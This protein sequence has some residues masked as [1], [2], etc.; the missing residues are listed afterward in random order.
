MKSQRGISALSLM[1]TIVIIIMVAGY[2]LL[3]SRDT[4][5]EGNVATVYSEMQE[6]IEAAKG[7][8]LD[9]D[10]LEENLSV[11]ELESITEMNPRVGNKLREGKKYYYFA[12]ADE[13]FSDVMKDSLNE[14][15]GLRSVSGSYIV[16]INDLGKVEVYLVDGININGK[17]CY[18]YEEIYA[19]YTEVNQK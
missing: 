16:A 2:S 13:D 3:F 8:S 17:F 9:M 6:L 11:F 18:S 15:L 10:Y 19:E 5:V 7:L 12:Y 4:I 14:V 1:I